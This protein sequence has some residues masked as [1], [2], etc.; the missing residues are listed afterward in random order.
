[1]PTLQSFAE[2]ISYGLL[3]ARCLLSLV[4]IASAQDKFRV[5]PAELA[6]LGRLHVP[7]PDLTCFHPESFGLPI[8]VKDKA[9]AAAGFGQTCA[10][11][12][13]GLRGHTE[14]TRT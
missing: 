8:A 6:M 7:F 5:P 10:R 9:P 13:M 11:C 4:F 1:M 14:M 2:L 3:A 12:D